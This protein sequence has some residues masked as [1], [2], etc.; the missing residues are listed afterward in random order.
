MPVNVSTKIVVGFED[1]LNN[2]STQAFSSLRNSGNSGGLLS[3]LSEKFWVG[4]HFKLEA[5]Q[6][7]RSNSLKPTNILGS[8]AHEAIN[9]QIVQGSILADES[10]NLL[11]PSAGMEPFA[12]AMEHLIN[13]NG[14]NINGLAIDNYITQALEFWLNGRLD[15]KLQDAF[16]RLLLFTRYAAIS[17]AKSFGQA[18]FEFS[19]ISVELSESLRLSGIILFNKFEEGMLGA[20]EELKGLIKLFFIDFETEI[21]G[22][23]EAKVVILETA[24]QRTGGFNPFSSILNK[25]FFLSGLSGPSA[26]ISSSPGILSQ[27]LNPGINIFGKE[28]HIKPLQINNIN[29]S[30]TDKFSGRREFEYFQVENIILNV[31]SDFSS[32]LTERQFAVELRDEI[33]RL[34]RRMSE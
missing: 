9:P 13:G 25:S 31:P 29:Q 18:L 3:S 16:D 20:I 10:S 6:E 21:I 4:K 24:A 26:G 5:L 32:R 2:I 12:T 22:I 11:L 33:I 14:F 34:D 23:S 28:R 7:S 19:R 8:M 30:G 1:C 17:M 15:I 27:P